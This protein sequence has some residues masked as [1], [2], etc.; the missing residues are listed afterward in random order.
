M[1]LS[2]QHDDDNEGVNAMNSI[3]SKTHVHLGLQNVTALKIES[4]M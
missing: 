4:Q 1:K 3:S 2:A